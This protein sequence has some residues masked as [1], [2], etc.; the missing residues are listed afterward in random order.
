M[1]EIVDP[2]LKAWATPRQ[3]EFIDAVNEYGSSREAARALGLASFA[4][5]NDA[6]RIVKSKAL[7]A[8]FAAKDFDPT[9]PAQV[10]GQV[11]RFL[12][13]AAQ[14]ETPVHE[15][16]LANLEAYARDIG[17]ELMIGGFTYQKGLFEDHA[18]RT[19]YFVERVRPYLRHEN[20]WCGPVLFAAKMN[21]LPTAVRPL[22]GL[23][24][25]SR[26][27]WAVFPHA[28]V[29]L[30]SVPSL[31]GRHPAMVMTTGACTLPNYIEKKAGLKAEFHH[32]IGATIVEID[33]AGRTFCR[34][35]G[36]DK[37]D[38]SFQDL[39]IRV[40]NGLVTRGH[41]VEQITAGDLHI[42]KGDPTVFRT[43]FGYDL[44]TRRVVTDDSLI[45]T[46]RP[47]SIALHDVLDFQTRN[48]HRRSDPHFAARMYAQGV[49]LVEEEVRQTADF[50]EAMEEL[51]PRVVVAASNHQDALARWL[52]E[53]DPRQEGPNARYWCELNAEWFRQ[54]ESGAGDFDPF[55]YAASRASRRGL[56]DVVFVPRNGSF[57]VCEDHGG[58]EVGMHGDEGPN[59][60]RGSALALT[61][62]ATRMNIGH[63]HTAGILDGVYTA[64]LCGLMDQGYNSGPSGWSHTQIVTY[65]NARRS[66]VTVLDGRFRA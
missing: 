55:K 57:V 24:T 13:T 15:P 16:F 53:A 7:A 27:A 40:R 60:A 44:V 22:S 19:G 58:I 10:V 3:A 63:A 2:R 54:I 65:S 42:E 59:G 1:S 56:G 11:R 36:A 5:I 26:G 39:D 52:R 64:G 29:Q 33:D 14:D 17:A 21:I 12:L 32:Q 49:H 20:E 62:V 43:V 46:L 61:R 41:R 4:N 50:L 37:V 6:I 18:T 66:L 23:E 38:G 35:I 51:D 8:G 31:P 47:R 9:P 34:Q 30:V 25:Y 48:H 28:K 45:G